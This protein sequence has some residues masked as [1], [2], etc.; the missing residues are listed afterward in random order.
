MD[1]SGSKEPKIKSEPVEENDEYPENVQFG[2]NWLSCEVKKEETEENSNDSNMSVENDE[3]TRQKTSID[4]GEFFFFFP[5]ANL[6]TVNFCEGP[7]F[8]TAQGSHACWKFGDIW[9][10]LNYSSRSGKVKK[11]SINHITGKENT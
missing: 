9:E 3:G 2:E 7:I 8:H 4:H 1:S 5:N 10:F 6:V 11:K